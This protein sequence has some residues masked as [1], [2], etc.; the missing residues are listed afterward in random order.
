MR[1]LLGIP[2][3]SDRTA[4]ALRTVAKDPRRLV[5]TALVSPEYLVN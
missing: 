2:T 5:A 4:I 1:H 3:L